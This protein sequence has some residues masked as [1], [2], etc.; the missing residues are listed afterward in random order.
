MRRRRLDDSTWVD[1]L[2]PM[3]PL[4][5]LLVVAH[6]RGVRGARH[7][8]VHFGD[9]GVGVHV[10]AGGSVDVGLG[11]ADGGRRCLG[12]GTYTRPHLNTT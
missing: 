2:F 12:A 4:P 9:V 6:G 3:T 1:C 8:V 11:H 10:L 7:T 5:L